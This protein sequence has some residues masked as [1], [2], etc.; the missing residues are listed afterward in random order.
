MTTPSDD[1][2]LKIRLERPSEALAVVHPAGR[3]DTSTS[4]AF[5]EVVWRLVEDETSVVVDLRR[6]TFVDATG[7]GVLVLLQKRLKARGHE[8]GIV[9]GRS[10][11]MRPF[12][13][14]GL[15]RAFRT[16]ASLGELEM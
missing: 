9:R 10:E 12:R 16:A 1:G 6:V 3:L 7:L 8:L 14:T 4:S 13:V 11:T 5:A 15:N 2:R